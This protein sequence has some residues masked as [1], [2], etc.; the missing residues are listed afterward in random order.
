MSLPIFPCSQVTDDNGRQAPAARVRYGGALRFLISAALMTG[1]ALCPPVSAAPKQGLSLSRLP[2]ENW[3]GHTAADV[4][5]VY[6]P[7][8]RVTS[9]QKVYDLAGQKPLR[10]MFYQRKAILVGIDHT[11][12]VQALLILPGFDGALPAGL[13]MEMKRTAITKRLGAADHEIRE[14]DG[15]IRLL[16]LS[17]AYDLTF[18]RR[19]DALAQF[20]YYPALRSM[21]PSKA[22]SPSAKPK[23]TR[24]PAKPAAKP[25]RQQAAPLPSP[26]PVATPR[27][28]ATPIR[29]VSPSPTPMA[30]ISAPRVSD[31]LRPA[32][33]KQASPTPRALLSPKAHSLPPTSA[34]VKRTGSASIVGLVSHFHAD[35][36]E[37]Q[38]LQGVQFYIAIEPLD[39]TLHSGTKLIAATQKENA[40][41]RHR[42]RIWE[43]IRTGKII[44]G[45][46]SD[47]FG[48]FKFQALPDGKCYL[49]GIYDDS[50]RYMV[51][52]RGI[53]LDSNRQYRTYLNRNNVSMIGQ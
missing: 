7:P 38:Y 41:A 1:S 22:A 19:T 33:T 4:E 13:R 3:L 8:E 36:G 31:A 45:I 23:P 53:R 40:K 43:L 25:S 16:Y 39:S 47:K 27:P 2:V 17:R 9:L 24:A 48:R 50:Q 20:L 21:A 32:T 30:R 46:E 5:N 6:G 52:Q 49:I 42:A 18:D 11:S 35:T 29:P 12:R 51:W 44:S 14:D 10:W 34:L 26:T 15:T 37:I 28:N